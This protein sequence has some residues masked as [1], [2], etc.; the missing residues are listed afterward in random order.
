MVIRSLGTLIPWTVVGS[1]S[2]YES[3]LEMAKLSVPDE[4]GGSSS[5]LSKD[6]PGWYLMTVTDAFE[7]KRQTKDG[8][9]MMDGISIETEVVGGENDGKRYTL[10]LWDPK[11][12][13]KDQGKSAAMKQAAFLIAT[14]VIT[15]EQL[16]TDIEY[17][18]ATSIGALFVIELVCGRPA[19]D[20]KV[21]L[22]VNYSNMFHVD[23]PRA[24]KLALDEGQKAR[25]ASYDQQFRHPAEYFE[26]LTAKKHD[27]KPKAK[28]LDFANL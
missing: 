19:S 10:N 13:S 2:F 21:Y 23:D 4:I 20:G 11:L 6:Q 15:P 22:E 3:V 27:A 14:D 24:G 12:S 28:E 5:F 8:F 1:H 9:E 18:A 16:G 25:V 17:E 7:G 26:R